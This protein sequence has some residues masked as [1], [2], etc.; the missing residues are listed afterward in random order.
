MGRVDEGEAVV[1]VRGELDLR[2]RQALGLERRD[3]AQMLPLAALVDL[4]EVCLGHV[5]QEPG[6]GLL[7]GLAVLLGELGDERLGRR[8]LIRPR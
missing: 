6:D 4:P 7:C 1:V 8:Q 2:H 3:H 5:R